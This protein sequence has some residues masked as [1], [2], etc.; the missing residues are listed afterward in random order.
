MLHRLTWCNTYFKT[1]IEQNRTHKGIST[2]TIDVTK[3]YFSDQ[4]Y[5]SFLLTENSSSFYIAPL[6]LCL[7]FL[8]KEA[9]SQL[10]ATNICLFFVIIPMS[11]CTF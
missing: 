11:L 9:R 3:H 5:D 2:K 6:A 4:G 8:V 1:V 7:L 10:A